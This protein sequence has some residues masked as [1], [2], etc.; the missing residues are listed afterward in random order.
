MVIEMP[1][2]LVAEVRCFLGGLLASSKAYFRI[3]SVPA[4]VKVACCTTVSRSVPSKMQPPIDEYSR[5]E[6][7]T[8]ELQSR[9]HLVCRLLLEK[10]KHK[11]TSRPVRELYLGGAPSIRVSM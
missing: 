2:D 1:F 7:H 3:R 4:R 5:S 11:H 6:E 8:S 10:K 9:P